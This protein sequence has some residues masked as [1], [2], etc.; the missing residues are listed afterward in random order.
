MLARR[1]VVEPHAGDQ[2]GERT[3]RHEEVGDRALDVLAGRGARRR[4]IIED[5]VGE[6]AAQDE[7]VRE[8]PKQDGRDDHRAAEH[9]LAHGAVD[10][11]RA[12]RELVLSGSDCVE[13][14][15]KSSGPYTTPRRAI[16]RNTRLTTSGNTS[17]SETRTLRDPARPS[18]NP[19]RKIGLAFQ[20][21]YPLLE[22]VDARDQLFVSQIRWVNVRV[23]P[24]IWPLLLSFPIM[25][26]EFRSALLLC[27]RRRLRPSGA[28]HTRPGIPVV[29]TATRVAFL[30]KLL[31]K[32][33]SAMSV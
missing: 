1:G 14:E 16:S 23:R 9:E 12:V 24:A 7:R 20:C 8:F 13:A 27:L 10:G 5:A 30:N 4:A 3:E 22:R 31:T 15:K 28:A 18:L 19:F 33:F 29:S 17:V 2:P 32:L 25:I 6:V 26:L 11:R 21:L